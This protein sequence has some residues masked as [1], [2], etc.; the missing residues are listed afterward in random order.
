LLCNAV[1]ADSLAASP[2]ALDLP[3]AL[4]PRTESFEGQEIAPEQETTANSDLNVGRRSRALTRRIEPEGSSFVRLEKRYTP[5]MMA[6]RELAPG[7]D[8]I[9]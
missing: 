7:D 6:P 1:E 4:A 3:S 5:F 9:V 8:A 2:E